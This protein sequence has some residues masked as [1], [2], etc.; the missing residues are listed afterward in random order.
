MTYHYGKWAVVVMVSE[1]V[2]GKFEVELKDPD[3]TNS[4]ARKE[5]KRGSDPSPWVAQR[6]AKFLPKWIADLHKRR[7]DDWKD[8]NYA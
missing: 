1:T 7:N 5:F 6:I 2:D 4:F 8:E 3:Y